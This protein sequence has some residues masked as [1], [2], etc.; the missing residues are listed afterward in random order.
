MGGIRRTTVAAI[1]AALWQSQPLSP[2][3]DYV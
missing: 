1:Y 3:P 2:S